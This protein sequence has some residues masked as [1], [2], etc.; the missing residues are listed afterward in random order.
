MCEDQCRGQREEQQR[1]GLSQ[2]SSGE[3]RVCLEKSLAGGSLS[4]G[5]CAAHLWL[6]LLITLSFSLLPLLGGTGQ[7]VVDS[8]VPVKDSA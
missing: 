1:K 3:P 8:V 2:E 6:A 4:A 7:E 5:R